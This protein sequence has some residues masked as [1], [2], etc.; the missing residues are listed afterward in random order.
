MPT[1]IPGLGQSHGPGRASA[2][3]SQPDLPLPLLVNP[4]C[5]RPGQPPPT[6]PDTGLSS[7]TSPRGLANPLDHKEKDTPTH[8]TLPHQPH[9]HCPEGFENPWSVRLSPGPLQ[10]VAVGDQS[11]G[12]SGGGQEGWVVQFGVSG[13]LSAGNLRVRVGREGE[14][15]P[16]S[17]QLPNFAWCLVEDFCDLAPDFSSRRLKLHGN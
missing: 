7:Q 2:H 16:G 17:P 14:G 5:P 12:R 6:S 1:P 15:A 10:Q 3:C 11:M 4:R 8:K 13:S 9:S